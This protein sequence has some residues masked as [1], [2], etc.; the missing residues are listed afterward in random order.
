MLSRILLVCLAITMAGANLTILAPVSAAQ[1]ELQLYSFSVSAGLDYPASG[2][3]FD[4]SGNLYGLAGGQG[5]SGI[6]FELSPTAG[7]GWTEQT[8][9]VFGLHTDGSQ[10][11]GNLIFD[12]SGNL[13]GA[14]IYGGAYSKGA[15]FELSPA[16]GGWTETSLYSFG[17]TSADGSSPVGSLI[18]DNSGNLYG[19]TESGG[20]YNFGTAFELSPAGGGNW[21]EKILHSFGHEKDAAVPRAGMVMDTSGNLYGTT[22][23]GGAHLND[24]TVFRLAPGTSGK[25][26][27]SV[28]FSF[29]GSDGATPTAGLA[30][31]SQGNLYGT[32]GGGGQ[33]GGGTV[34]ELSPTSTPPWT[35]KV[36]IYFKDVNGTSG[37]APLAG[38]VF[39]SS[40]NFYGTASVGGSSGGL[41]PP[42]PGGGGM[43]YKFNPGTGSYVQLYNFNPYSGSGDG[44]VPASTLILDGAGNVYGTTQFGGS[45]NA[46]TVFEINSSAPGT[47]RR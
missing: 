18:F 17:S 10:P 11:V 29:S 25:W 41:V 45:S 24:G 4:A 7:G 46:G 44:A 34:F 8:L 37:F 30:L 9:H 47:R 1:Q 43:I 26:T 27:E 15:V 3:I 31:D 23:S 6:A 28:L 36:L 20:S 13:Y 38:V 42:I 32:T 12:A 21:T 22:Y 40:G 5:S 33:N 2:L 16:S 19:T 14:T 35:E 39:D